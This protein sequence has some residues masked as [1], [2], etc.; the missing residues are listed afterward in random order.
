MKDLNVK[1]KTIKI[2]KENTGSNLFDLCQSNFLLV[3]LLEAKEKK[4]N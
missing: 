3:M 1:Q 2:L 4:V